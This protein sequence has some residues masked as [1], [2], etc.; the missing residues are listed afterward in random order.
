MSTNAFN[1]AQTR[2]ALAT[3]YEHLKQPLLR[4]STYKHK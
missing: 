3:R 1:N 4:S 2:Q